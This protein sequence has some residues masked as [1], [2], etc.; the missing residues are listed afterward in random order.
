MTAGEVSI[1]HS[2]A[3]TK[4]VRIA[5]V[6][7]ASLFFEK[8]LRFDS[9]QLTSPKGSDPISP[10]RICRDCVLCLGQYASYTTQDCRHN[11]NRGRGK[12]KG[13]RA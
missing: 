10:T 6:P 11:N 8:V 5:A 1:C 7:G 12:S 4:I 9:G 13:F 2:I 3:L